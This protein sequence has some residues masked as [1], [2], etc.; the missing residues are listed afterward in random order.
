LDDL[1]ARKEDEMSPKQVV[2]GKAKPAD[3]SERRTVTVEEAGR[4]LGIS[5]GSAYGLA[6][7][8]ELPTIRLGKR[9]LVPKSAIER[10]LASA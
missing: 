8:G 2:S 6:K 1:Q 7:A 10:L 4:I 9:I 3:D 5:R